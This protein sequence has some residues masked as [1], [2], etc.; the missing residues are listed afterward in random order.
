[1]TTCTSLKELYS[2]KIYVIDA[3]MGK[4]KSCVTLSQK[5]STSTDLKTAGPFFFK[6][7]ISN[8]IKYRSFTLSFIPNY[9]QY[10]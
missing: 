10:S 7:I 6:I 1:M 3:A 8:T 4:N 5:S 9:G 2:F